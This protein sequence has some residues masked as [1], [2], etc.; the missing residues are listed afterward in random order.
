MYDG[1]ADPVWAAALTLAIL[2]GGTQADEVMEVDGVAQTRTPTATV[3]GSG[4]PGAQVPALGPLSVRDGDAVT[5]VEA[6]PVEIGLARLV[7]TDVPTDAGS[8]SGR[9][10][11]SVP[12]LLAGLRTR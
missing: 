9:W 4:R 1:C 10:N 7:G 5:V 3:E 12:V 11:G 2:T 8:L 6:G